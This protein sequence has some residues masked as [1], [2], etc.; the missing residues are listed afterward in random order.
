M[1]L[2]GF[3]PIGLIDNSDC[4]ILGSLLFCE[5]LGIFFYISMFFFFSSNYCFANLG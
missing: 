5:L 2:L 1:I 3:G 4:F